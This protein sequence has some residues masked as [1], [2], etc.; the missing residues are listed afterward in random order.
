MENFY[1]QLELSRASIHVMIFIWKEGTVIR[2]VKGG[3]GR[4]KIEKM[5]KNKFRDNESE[6]S[7]R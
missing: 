5:L 1:D 7:G 6:Q 3:S 4:K 2:K